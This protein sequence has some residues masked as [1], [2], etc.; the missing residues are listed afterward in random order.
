MQPGNLKLQYMLLFSP[1]NSIRVFDATVVIQLSAARSLLFHRIGLSR[2]VMLMILGDNTEIHQIR[3]QPKQSNNALYKWCHTVKSMAYCLGSGPIHIAT[4]VMQN[5]RNAFER[6]LV[7]SIQYSYCYSMYIWRVFVC[8]RRALLK[9]TCEGGWGRGGERG[10][11]RRWRRGP[12]WLAATH[13]GTFSKQGR[14][15]NTPGKN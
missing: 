8:W 10:R 14:K 11:G 9:A 6:E 15:S 3:N 12:G 1:I 5:G 13:L 7:I 2:K 4:L